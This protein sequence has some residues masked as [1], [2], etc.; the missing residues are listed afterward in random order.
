[1]MYYDI[2]YG[3]CICIKAGGNTY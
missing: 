1:M 2:I 3:A